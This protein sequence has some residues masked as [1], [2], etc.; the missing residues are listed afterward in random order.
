MRLMRG[1]MLLR[2]SPRWLQDRKV[3]PT[4]RERLLGPQPAP[5]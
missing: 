4:L 2:Q 5:Q 1:A 3:K